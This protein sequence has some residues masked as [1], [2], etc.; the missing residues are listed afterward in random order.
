MQICA[1]IDDITLVKVNTHTLPKF[2]NHFRTSF[3]W[4]FPI[5]QMNFKETGNERT[6]KKVAYFGAVG[7]RYFCTA[8][9]QAEN[10][11]KGILSALHLI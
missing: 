7:K 1:L 9:F 11:L 5:W 6:M 3:S 2:P 4:L 10:G 8:T